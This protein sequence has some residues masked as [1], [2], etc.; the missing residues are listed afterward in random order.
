MLLVIS[1]V[2]VLIAITPDATVFYSGAGR[3]S[4]GVIWDTNGRIYR[5]DMHPGGGTSDWGDIFS[6]EHFFMRFEWRGGT[7][8]PRCIEITP[9]LL[10]TRIY[11]DANGNLDTRPGSK[12]DKDQIRPC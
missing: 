10:G 3:Q 1:P 11:I 4:I 5:S 12:T 7:T 6:D 9:T 2:L 8:G